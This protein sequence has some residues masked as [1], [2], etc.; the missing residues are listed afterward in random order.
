M[1]TILK[2]WCS[3]SLFQNTK[4]PYMRLRR[5]SH[6][7]HVWCL[8]VYVTVA[9]QQMR[10]GIQEAEIETHGRW[11]S[12][13]SVAR[14][15]KQGRYLDDLHRLPPLPT[16]APRNNGVAI[17]CPRS[18]RV[19]PQFTCGKRPVVHSTSVQSLFLF[20]RRQCTCHDAPELASCERAH[21]PYSF[22][23]VGHTGS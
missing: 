15:E 14:D 9:L 13:E 17:D 21:P 4:R 20:P 6:S 11:Q 7:T 23:R 22:A 1:S 8:T 19:D 2:I 10:S 3:L 12:R 18:W 5:G 16:R